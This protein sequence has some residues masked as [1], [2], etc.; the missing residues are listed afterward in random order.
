[1]VRRRPT[2]LATWCCLIQSAA[3]LV[4]TVCSLLVTMP[5]GL[6][7]RQG[8]WIVGAGLT[9]SPLCVGA[10]LLQKAYLVHER[11]KW[12]LAIALMAPNAGCFSL[13]PPYLPWVKIAMDAPINLA[14]SIAFILVVYRQYRQYG[15]A[16]WGRL[17]RNG[18]QTM[19]FVVLANIA[20]Y[21]AF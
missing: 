4:Y 20:Y 6:S 18:I 17:V 12:L 19:C 2:A 16:A 14:F 3:G 15:S 10:T 13:Y 8:M 7:C 11:K 9:I 5:G 21:I 1:M